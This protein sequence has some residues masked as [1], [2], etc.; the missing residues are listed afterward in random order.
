MEIK[1]RALK[2]EDISEYVKLILRTKAG[3]NR[4]EIEKI[5]K[6]S[7]EKGIKPLNPDYFVLTISGKIAGISGLYYDYE[8]P[9]DV[10]W[11]DYFAV[12]PEFQRQ[13]LGTT[14]L[15]NLE[16]ICQK[17]KT[18]LLCVFTETEE[19]LKFW[20]KNG[21]EIFGRIDDYYAKDRPKIWLSKEIKV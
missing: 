5:I 7:L 19:S 8:D 13:G 12:L 4:K 2:K 14:M 1:I 16:K 21:F 9:A 17:K 11:I 10:L 20:R 6:N 18:R 3:S 15:E